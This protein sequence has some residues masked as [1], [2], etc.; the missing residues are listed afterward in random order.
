MDIELK[1]KGDT[2]F[3]LSDY[4]IIVND[5]VVESIETEDKYKQ[6]DGLHGRFLVQSTYL[7]RQI[8]VTCFFVANKHNTYHKQRDLLYSLVND[9]EPFYLREKRRIEELSYRFRDTTSDDYQ[10]IDSNGFFKSDNPNNENYHVSGK[11]YLV[12]LANVIQP[13]QSRLKGNIELVFETTSL[14][15]AESIGRST[16]L[17]KAKNL[18]LWSSD[19]NIPFNENYKRNYTFEYLEKGQFYYHGNVTINQFNMDSIVEITLGEDTKDFSWF[20]T[21]SSTMRIKGANLKAGDIIKYDGL[22]VFRN[23]VVILNYS[24]KENPVIVPGF[25]NFEFNQQVRKVVFDHKFY[26]G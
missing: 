3:S 23:G 12:K 5:I 21:G 19:M 24:N 25:N 17:E 7:K 8:N 10:E 6:T 18:D 26:F 15:F 4:G 1:K 22:R 11:R 9:T 13:K 2:S 20:M 14:P 16:D